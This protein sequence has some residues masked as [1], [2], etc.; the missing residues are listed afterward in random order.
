MK[1]PT[2]LHGGLDWLNQISNQNPIALSKTGQ[3]DSIARG[4]ARISGKIRPLFQGRGRRRPPRGPGSAEKRRPS[5]PFSD[6][7]VSVPRK[8]RNISRPT[9]ILQLNRELA[10]AGDA[11]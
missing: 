7:F 10:G 4:D 11:G 6:I 1:A 9:T 2:A 5:L 8:T 3:E